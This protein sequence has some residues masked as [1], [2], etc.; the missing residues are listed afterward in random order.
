MEGI[1]TEDRWEKPGPNDGTIV[2]KRIAGIGSYAYSAKWGTTY[3][4][5]ASRTTTKKLSRSE[6]GKMF[7][8]K[9]SGTAH[10]G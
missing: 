4:E 1:G 3:Q 10:A 7:E 2:Y 8:E 5:N 6:V 9:I